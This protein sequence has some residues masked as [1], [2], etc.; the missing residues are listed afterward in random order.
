M[1]K[2]RKKGIKKFW[3]FYLINKWSNKKIFQFLN[4]QK[5]ITIILISQVIADRI[6][7]TFDA[8]NQKIPTVL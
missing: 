4:N 6:R 1:M 8:Y 7:D 2:W 3:N 5:I